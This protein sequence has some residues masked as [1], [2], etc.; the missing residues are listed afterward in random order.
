[1][2]WRGGTPTI[3]GKIVGILPVDH[4]ASPL[5]STLRHGGDT[6]RPDGE[7]NACGSRGVL[8]HAIFEGVGLVHGGHFLVVD[9]ETERLRLPVDGIIVVV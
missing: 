5:D 6:S 1:M 8:I 9:E 4:T 7:L 2:E 3:V